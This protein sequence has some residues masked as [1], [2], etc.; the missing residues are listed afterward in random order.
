MDVHSRY[1]HSRNKSF[2]RIPLRRMAA[3]SIS[4]IS[5]PDTYNG[6]NTENQLKQMNDPN[7]CEEADSM[8]REES[9]SSSVLDDAQKA[10][11]NSISVIDMKNVPCEGKTDLLERNKESEPKNYL[12][13]VLISTGTIALCVLF[14]I[15]WTTVPRTDSIRYQSYWFET[16]LPHVTLTILDAAAQLLNLTVWT[17]ENSLAT[18]STFLKVF[19]SHLVPHIGVYLI[20]YLVWSAHLGFNHPLPYLG[21]VVFLVEMSASKI[22]LWFVLPTQLL[23]NQE[24]RRKLWVYMLYCFASV[25]VINLTE[26]LSYLFLNPPGGIQL[27]VP[28]IFVAIRELDYR[29]RAKCVEKM[30]Q[31]DDEASLALIDIIV[32]VTYAFFVAVRTVEIE[33]STVGLLL[34][35]EFL[36]HL[37]MTYQIIK[38]HKRIGL[39]NVEDDNKNL[40]STLVI[41]ILTELIEGFVPFIHGI[42]MAMA[43]YGPN[44]NLLANIG[45]TYWGTKIEDINPVLI[46]MIV[47][48]AVDFLRVI[49]TSVIL[50]KVIKI[51]FFREFQRVLESYW[52]FMVIYFAFGE[53]VYIA[54]TDINLGT[55]TSGKFLWID[56]EG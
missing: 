5:L 30:V 14:F 10:I 48:F 27:L 22:G 52:L 18:L 11:E 38:E 42:C 4:V 24:F 21:F 28:F 2:I 23:G 20:S 8:P 53:A 26:T 12:K 54:T 15:P 49:I 1:S 56:Q 44:S 45:D 16:W 19:L 39:D 32:N 9:P 40:K 25:M 29:I 13:S 36:L 6:A 55:D 33:I 31:E 17:K 34:A 47:L 51:N 43:Y 50:W 7:F 41:L 46:S 3:D 37:K 35:M